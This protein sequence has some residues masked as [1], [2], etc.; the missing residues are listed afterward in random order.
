MGTFTFFESALGTV[1]YLIPDSLTKDAVED[2]VQRCRPHA[3]RSI[4]G[5]PGSTRHLIQAKLHRKRCAGVVGGYNK[6]R[7]L[8]KG[9]SAC[10]EVPLHAHMPLVPAVFRKTTGFGPKLGSAPIDHAIE[11]IRHAPCADSLKL[12]LDR[13]MKT[14]DPDLYSPGLSLLLPVRRRSLHRYC[15]RSEALWPVPGAP[16][17]RPT[18]QTWREVFPRSS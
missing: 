2:N 4:S 6:F 18:S 1:L 17:Q 16:A 15:N 5:A 7:L 10:A 12:H 8:D 11:V 3:A 13:N 14:N 9:C